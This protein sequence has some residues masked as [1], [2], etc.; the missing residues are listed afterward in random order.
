MKF[1]FVPLTYF[2]Q[3]KDHH[4]GTYLSLKDNNTTTQFG[5]RL[6][7]HVKPATD[8][9]ILLLLKPASS[10]QGEPQLMMVTGFCILIHQV[11]SLS[12]RAAC[13]RGQAK[14]ARK[15]N[16]PANPAKADRILLESSRIAGKHTETHGSKK[17]AFQG[18]L[19][20]QSSRQQLGNNHNL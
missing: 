16:Y 10:E 7:W 1:C 18:R 5:I 9:S 17:R 19:R 20:K 2:T 13:P 11:N 6:G 15:A 3:V 8:T 4:L 14:H 12:F